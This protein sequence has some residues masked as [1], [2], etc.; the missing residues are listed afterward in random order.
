MSR[1]GRLT[2][3]TS[4]DQYLAAILDELCTIRAQLVQEPQQ[5]NPDQPRLVTEPAPA[6]AKGG[7]Q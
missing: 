4:T 1:P 7:P 2:P 6:P 3:L 5:P